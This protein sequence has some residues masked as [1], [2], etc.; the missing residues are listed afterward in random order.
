MLQDAEA[1]EL[2]QQGVGALPFEQGV[3]MPEE[4]HVKAFQDWV[5]QRLRD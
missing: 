3:L 2:N 5:R 1:S 4:H